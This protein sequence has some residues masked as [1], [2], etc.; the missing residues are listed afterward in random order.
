MVVFVQLRIFSIQH[1][2]KFSSQLH[3]EQHLAFLIQIKN[4]LQIY[5]IN[6]LWSFF[7]QL[8]HHL[9]AQLQIIFLDPSYLSLIMNVANSL[10]NRMSYHSISQIIFSIN[11]T[12]L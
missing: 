9:S 7:L 1:Q 2:H 4:H 8:L 3:Q 6:V 10:I 5:K 11:L 12:K